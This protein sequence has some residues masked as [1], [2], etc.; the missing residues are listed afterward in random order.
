MIELINMQNK[1][2]KYVSLVLLTTSILL[3]SYSVL[4]QNSN[5]NTYL[6]DNPGN[7]DFTYHKNNNIKSVS[8][9]T[10]TG[11]YDIDQSQEEVT[12]GIMIGNMIVCQGVENDYPPML[13]FSVYIEEKDSSGNSEPLYIGLISSKLV[14]NE[15]YNTNN[16]DV[17]YSL[18]SGLLPS[19]TPVW[20]TCVLQNP[21]DYESGEKFY[22]ILASNDLVSSDGYFIWKYSNN[23]PYS[24]GKTW[25]YNTMTQTRHEYNNGWNEDVFSQAEINSCYSDHPEHV[26]SS[27]DYDCIL[28]YVFED[29][30]WDNFWF[31]DETQPDESRGGTL[32]HIQ[33]DTTY[34]IKVSQDIDLVFHLPVQEGAWQGNNEWD[35]CFVTWTDFPNEDEGE[36]AGTWNLNEGWN[37]VIF[38]QGNL[39]AVGSDNVEE[40]FASIDHDCILNYVFEDG[41][42]DNF[43]F[44]D[45]SDPQ[46]S[47]GGTL[48]TIHPG[49]TY[50]VAVS[51]DCT[52]TITTG[53]GG[54]PP[55]PEEPSIS[56]SLT[57]QIIQA[58]GILS[59][60]GAVI[61]GAKHL[62][63]IGVL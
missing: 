39:N 26:F 60:I 8:Y 54:D 49:V 61:S 51:Q 31:C 58:T 7:F 24:S 46:G 56:I 34:H 30:T 9:L 62:L 2:W 40:V 32:Q 22:I 15:L 19:D 17:V 5:F 37:E 55:E 38:T 18:D 42:W 11:T 20:F 23:A 50:H 36:E 12:G 44:C 1:K 3:L 13:A 35:T 10:D 57:A 33:P 43:W 52:L 53:G 25:T 14:G 21:V 29:G 16:W 48:Q 59:L 41:T 63:I 4:S 6:S 27:I 45:D 28:N 47:R